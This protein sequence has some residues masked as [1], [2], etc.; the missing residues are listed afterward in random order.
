MFKQGDK[1]IHFTKYGGI[2]KGEVESCGETIKWDT[3]NMVAY[4]IPYMITTIGHT[5]QLD[6]KDGHVYKIKGDITEEMLR[7]LK[8]SATVFEELKNRKEEHKKKTFEVFEKRTEE[9]REYLKDAKF[10]NEDGTVVPLSDAIIKKINKQ[11]DERS[12]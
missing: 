7:R 8:G 1:Y 2:N 5:I 10:K 9:A 11:I 6:G 12:I 4:H 3:Q